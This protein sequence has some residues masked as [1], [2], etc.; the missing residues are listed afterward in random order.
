MVRICNCLNPAISAMFQVLCPYSVDGPKITSF[1]C[2]NRTDDTIVL[3]C[4]VEC[5]L[6]YNIT[7]LYGGENIV[8]LNGTEKYITFCNDTESFLLVKNASNA[9][10][11]KNYTCVVDTSYRKGDAMK[12]FSFCKLSSLA[13]AVLKIF[14]QIFLLFSFQR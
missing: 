14:Y 2:S 7:W 1:K 8:V 6:P 5:Y 9:D 4:E 13:E 3:V 11:K 10:T 12:V